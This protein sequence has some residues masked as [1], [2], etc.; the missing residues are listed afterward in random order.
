V[1]LDPHQEARAQRLHE[2]S[3]VLLAHDH[4]FPPD[5]LVELRRGKVTGKI[6]MAVVDARLWSGNP[7]DYR[8]SITETDG[9][10][11]TACE[12]YQGLCRTIDS[13]PDFAL[14]RDAGDVL[15][16]KRQGK[17]G[18]LLGAEGGKLVEDRLGNLRA[19][20]DLGLRHLLL[21]WAFNNQLSAAERDT[22]GRGLTDL[23]R[24]VVGEMN[25]LGMIIDVTHL[26]RPAMREVL[27]LSS[28]PVLNSHTSLRSLANRVPAL[29]EHEV[30]TL[31]ENG[32][33]I[34]LHFMTHM[35]TGRF[36]P[37]AGLEDV[38]RQIDA[39][40]NVGGIDC[41]ALGPDYLPYTEEFKRNTEQWNL[42]FPAGLESPAGLIH[43]VRGLVARGYSDEAVEKILGGNLL[44]LF[45]EALTTPPSESTSRASPDRRRE[46]PRCEGGSPR[47]R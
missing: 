17:V 1:K 16:A 8:R 35:L 15:D 19:L 3:V 44:R 24:Q 5:D 30:R 6:L 26:S 14:I 21:T 18:I 37:R 12:A 2:E 13:S 10:F 46:A 23:G 39:L 29:D 27:A 7:E 33:V 42:S 41:L 45:R 40:V 28:R 22:E 34:A 25:R 20:Y 4:F 9:W 11:A 36:S 32:G 38:L 43:L 31:A 47:P